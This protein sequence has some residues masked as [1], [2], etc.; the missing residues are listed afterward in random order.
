VQNSIIDA[1]F[2]EI[3]KLPV[4]DELYIPCETKQEQK[5]IKRAFFRQIKEYS[6]VQAEEASKLQIAD[7][8]RDGRLWILATR[9]SQSPLVGFKK[10]SSG[11]I[12]KFIVTEDPARRRR[13]EMMIQDRLPKKEINDLL[14]PPLTEEEEKEFF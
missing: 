1:W 6:F 10:S 14:D 8:F 4:G 3:L 2:R 9:K 12:A 7:T 5:N 11:K 13:I